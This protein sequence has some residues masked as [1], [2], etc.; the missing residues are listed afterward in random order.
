VSSKIICTEC[1]KKQQ[2][3]DRLREEIVC[4]KAKIRYQE[5]QITEGFFTSQTPSSKKPFKAN[6]PA[7]GEKKRGG[8]QV[9]HPGHGRESFSEEEA[10]EVKRIRTHSL[11]PDCGC[12]LEHKG[13]RKRRV[14]DIDPIHVKKILYHLETKQCPECRKKYAAQAPG[15]FPKCL[16]GNN[17]LTWIAVS[18]YLE[19]TPLGRL[20]SRLGIGSGTMLKALHRVA[21]IMKEVPE[22]L[23]E[24]WRSAPV[25]HADET[26]WRN[27]GRNGYGW[28][29]ATPEVSIFRFRTTRSAKVAREVFGNG[30]L[31]GVLVVDR[32]N[33]YNRAPCRIQYCYAH[34]LRNIQD[35]EKEFPDNAEIKTF[36]GRAAP[37]L[38][39]AM[40]LRSLPIDEETFYRRAAD[41]KSEI[42]RIM[43]TD[44]NHAG[45]QKIQ[46]IFR[47]NHDRLYHWADDRNVP[48]ENNYAEREL[49]PVVIARKLSFGS[50]SPKGA[51][52]REILMSVLFSLKKIEKNNT[53]STLK[54]V[55]DQIASGNDQT[56]FQLLFPDK[57]PPR[58]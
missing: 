19:G 3:I 1:F 4:L 8:A 15:V 7:A 18:H 41:T 53:F 47:E 25:K 21:E 52:I 22:K 35:L 2:E 32:Y 5:R 43:S 58:E 49:R 13:Y 30:P 42:I 54:N 12:G 51:K 17:L 29:F 44:A 34:L 36:I 40:H 23:I 33:G 56:P 50:H 28:L 45:I 48:A 31:P 9:G 57:A 37:L 27:D 6:A 16:I 39:E 55:L 46:N 38:A 11:C 26:V 10:G 14:I 24:H 20:E